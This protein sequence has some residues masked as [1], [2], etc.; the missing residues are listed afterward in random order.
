MAEKLDVPLSVDLVTD[1]T[2]GGK[3]STIPNTLNFI[4]PFLSLSWT[5][6]ILLSTE[7]H[8]FVYYGTS[9]YF[10]GIVSSLIDWYICTDGVHIIG[11]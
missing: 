5:C 11:Q 8:I 4:L 2:T 9:W 1:I 6:L 3:G 7:V 10:E